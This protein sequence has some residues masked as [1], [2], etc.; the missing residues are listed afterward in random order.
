M[1]VAGLVLA[2]AA[3]AWA[4]PRGRAAAVLRRAEKPADLPLVQA[5][6]WFAA[7]LDR[8]AVEVEPRRAWVWA[9]SSPLLGAGFGLAVGGFAVAACLAVLVPAIWLTVLKLTHNRADNS[10]RRAVAPFLEAVASALRSGAGVRAAVEEAVPPAAPSLR[11]DIETMRAEVAAG[12]GV[13]RAFDRL[14]E[15]RPSP[16]MRL[17]AAALDLAAAGGPAAQA[18]DGVAATLRQRAAAAADARALGSQARL[19]A[20]VIAVAPLA[21]MA[22]AG[23]G[24]Q[25][26]IRFLTG[27]PIGWAVLAAG[28]ALDGLGALWMARLARAV[29]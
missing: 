17:A 24:D 27:T 5:P 13:T 8:S 19:S 29:S 1:T 10:R 21:F 22:L 7:A 16:E 25:R 12:A 2:A 11:R 6:D 20:V 4:L 18:I 14:A 26:S 15:R 9:L 28:L 23:L 3:A